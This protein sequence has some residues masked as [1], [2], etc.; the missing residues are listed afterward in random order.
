MT[1]LYVIKQINNGYI[2]TIHEDEEV[3]RYA[4]DE[5]T[6]LNQLLNHLIKRVETIRK[7]EA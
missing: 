5:V 1:N 4:K 7:Q 3:Q 2:V 6:A